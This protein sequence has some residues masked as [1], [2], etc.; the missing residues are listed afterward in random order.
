MASLCLLVVAVFD[1][2]TPWKPQIIKMCLEAGKK[3]MTTKAK[4]FI[5]ILLLL[6]CVDPHPSFLRLVFG[7]KLLSLLSSF[8]VKLLPGDTVCVCVWPEDI[9][10]WLK[11]QNNLWLVVDPL[12]SWINKLKRTGSPRRAWIGA[13]N[14]VTVW[15]RVTFLCRMHPQFS[16]LAQAGY[17]SN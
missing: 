7:I 5:C 3:K 15:T 17:Q 2:K 14:T 10:L 6:L 13:N 8:H 16:F 9:E 1:A 4:S 12:F 11:R